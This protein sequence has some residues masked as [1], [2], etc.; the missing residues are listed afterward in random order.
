MVTPEAT[1][2]SPVRTIGSSD[3]AGAM[4]NHREAK[5]DNGKPVD[6]LPKP[7]VTHMLA[8]CDRWDDRLEPIRRCWR[9][10]ADRWNLWEC[11]GLTE[12]PEGAQ[13]MTG[14]PVGWPFKTHEAAGGDP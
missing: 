3:G 10:I 9:R 14:E 6:T 2:E 4:K 11:V 1:K 7:V 8:G 13:W 12:R 5:K